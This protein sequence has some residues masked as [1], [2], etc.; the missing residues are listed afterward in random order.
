MNDKTRDLIMPYVREMI[1]NY[2]EIYAEAYTLTK[3]GQF[4]KSYYKDC[5]LSSVCNAIIDTTWI[6]KN[7]VKNANEHLRL[8]IM[9]VTLSF[10]RTNKLNK[11][12]GQMRGSGLYSGD[13][14]NR[15]KKNVSGEATYER[16]EKSI[17]L[18]VDG[19]AE[20]CLDFIDGSLVYQLAVM[21]TLTRA[22]STELDDILTN[23]C[24]TNGDETRRYDF[25]VDVIED[26]PI[27]IDRV[28]DRFKGNQPDIAESIKTALKFK[29]KLMGD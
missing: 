3:G 24:S 11:Y 13:F 26:M 28:D 10:V 19:N 6:K 22:E 16:A 15:A 4:K 8:W 1:A 5:P 23:R 7:K 29:R 27:D 12:L 21:F 18:S 25:L 20:Y 14:I 17:G 9:M 2:N